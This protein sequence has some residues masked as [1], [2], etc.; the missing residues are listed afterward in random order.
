MTV[1]RL[2]V[3][4]LVCLFGTIGVAAFLKNRTHSKE[5]SNKPISYT[6]VEVKLDEIVL[7]ADLIPET[8]RS[9]MEDP[10]TEEPIKATPRP[11]T[12]LP[13]ADRIQEFFNLQDPKLPIVETIT[14]RSRVSWQTGRP[15][16]LSDYASHYET[17]RH[18]IAR[19]LNGKPD[20][21]KQEIAE[22]DRVNVLR[23]D[24]NFRF[25]LVVDTSRCKMWFYYIDLD[26]NTP[27]LIKT[28]PVG[29]GRIDSSKESGL[30][31]PLGTYT[32]GKRVA[33]YKASSMGP[34]NGKNIAMITVFGTRWIPFEKEIENCT[35]LAKGFGV[36]GT[37]WS[38]GN[39]TVEQIESI[40]KY[41][42]D[43]CIRMASQDI[44]EVYAIII[45]KPTQ[46]EIVKDYTA[47]TIA[48]KED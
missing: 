38:I 40:G 20:Y 48:Q 32:L 21:L 18:F 3:F 33:I 47:S 42:S 5:T 10:S 13:D 36:H 8:P 39:Q 28:Y 43:G 37:P 2:F 35:S 41:E 9:S 15:A 34:Y 27:T 19:S 22:G 23:K 24:K 25:H 4:V 44:E 1:F 7:T 12:D 26:T 31:T 46:I 16:W 17:S 6:P 11:S 30:L 14:Y 45:T 29:L